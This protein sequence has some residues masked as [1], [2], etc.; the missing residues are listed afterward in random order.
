MIL[1]F[2]SRQPALAD[3][4]RLGLDLHSHL[5]PGIDDGAANLELSLSYLRSLQELGFRKLI[6]T[7]HVYQE[8]YPNTAEGI[9]QGAVELR[10]AAVA[11]G[12]TVELAVAAEYFLDDH[13]ADLVEQ[14][15]LLPLWERQVLVEMAFLGA[16]PQLEQ[17]LF[18]M[19]TKGYAPVLAHPERYA[20]LHGQWR[21]YERLKDLGCRFQ[22]NLLS[23]TGY[24]GK[25]VQQ[26]AEK[27]LAQGWVDYLGTDLHHQ[28]HLERLQAGLKHRL[29][30]KAVAQIG[31]RQSSLL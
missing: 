3:Y 23:L 22:V 6:T 29:L 20:F 15:A 14:E 24:Y 28:R 26:A 27:L 9:L 19:Q 1:S 4:S 17:Y 2:F 18:R 21:Q 11:A 16:P 12:I 10:A 25:P 8:F 31:E 7:P 30:A 13:F 5:L